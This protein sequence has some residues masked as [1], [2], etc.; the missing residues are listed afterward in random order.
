VKWSDI[1]KKAKDMGLSV[2]RMSKADVI[3]AIQA[4]EGNFPCFGSAESECDQTDCCWREDCLP[5]V[6]MG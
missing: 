5:Q 6:K 1:R 2:G 4:K 3:R